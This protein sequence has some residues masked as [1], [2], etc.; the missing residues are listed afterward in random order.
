MIVH[1]VAAS[2]PCS[3][4]HA[5]IRVFI[6]FFLRLGTLIKE[7]TEKTPFALNKASGGL[8]SA[9]WLHNIQ[10]HRC[11]WDCIEK[12]RH[13]L[14]DETIEGTLETS[15]AVVNSVDG[16]V[17]LSFSILQ[18]I[19]TSGWAAR[20]EA[21]RQ[22]TSHQTSLL[23]HAIVTK[24]GNISL[25]WHLHLPESFQPLAKRTTQKIFPGI[26]QG[27]SIFV[28]RVGKSFALS[29]TAGLSVKY[30]GG[31]FSVCE[32]VLGERH[33]LPHLGTG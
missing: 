22:W 27:F 4:I 18:L 8:A 29:P 31:C 33:H 17:R 20:N 11:G 28:W 9:G 14:E 7:E 24:N 10:F 32:W 13:R 21:Q 15:P 26:L 5:E 16:H 19:W 30:R 2:S 3:L 6:L 25:R 1:C 12:A 23:R